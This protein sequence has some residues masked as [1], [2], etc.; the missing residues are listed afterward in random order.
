MLQERKA[1][2]DAPALPRH[3]PDIHLAPSAGLGPPTVLRPHAD[4][5]P[6]QERVPANLHGRG[7]RLVREQVLRLRAGDVAAGEAAQV[8]GGA[9]AGG[10]W[11]VLGGCTGRG[12]IIQGEALLVEFDVCGLL[13][14][15]WLGVL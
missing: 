2:P 9:W 1:Q 8:F 6:G 13:S 11:G 7:G 12:V 5:S 3:P 14:C 10:V 4:V 15:G